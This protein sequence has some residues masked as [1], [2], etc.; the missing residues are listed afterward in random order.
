M[1]IKLE[2]KFYSGSQELT[3]YRE[4]Y[5]L[6][7]DISLYRL[8]NINFRDKLRDYEASSIKIF[9]ANTNELILVYSQ[10][11]E[12]P[13]FNSTYFRSLDEYI[14]DEQLRGSLLLPTYDNKRIPVMLYDVTLDNKFRVIFSI[15]YICRNL[16]TIGDTLH[17]LSSIYD[18]STK[19]SDHV[20]FRTYTEVDYL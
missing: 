9:D 2:E 16:I 3:W 17:E 19:Y 15:V 14:D 7:Y 13:W 8:L 12:N 11:H 1:I 18:F 4:Y 20:Y 5:D 10:K 6:T